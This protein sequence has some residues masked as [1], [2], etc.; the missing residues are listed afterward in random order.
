MHKQ[1]SSRLT[2]IVTLTVAVALISLS[3][4]AQSNSVPQRSEIDDKYKWDLTGFFPSDQAW[5]EEF[6]SVQAGLERLEF[7]QGKLGNSAANLLACLTLRDS[8]EAHTH[9]LYAYANLKNDQ[10]TR[11]SKYQ[12]MAGR[13]V[14]LWGQLSNA[15]SFIQ[16]E[17]TK[18]EESQV[19]ALLR[20]N[21]ALKT[22]RFFLEDIL[23]TKQ[24]ILS[25]KEEAI[26][27]SAFEVTNQPGRIFDMVDDADMDYGTIIDDNGEEIVLT[28]QRYSR[29]LESPDRETRRR[30]SEAYNRAYLNLQNTLA[31]LMSASF[32]GDYFYANTRG[33]GSCL[34]ASLDGNNIPP[35]VFHNLIETT[36]EHLPKLHKWTAL[37]KQV[38]GLDTLYK[39]DQ[40][41][42]LVP[43]YTR[44]FTY[45][46]AMELVKE[47]LKPLGKEYTDDV[48]MAFDS[49]WVDVY[50][51]EGKR[52]GG[53]QWGSYLAH[54]VILMNFT[55]NLEEVF[56]L[57]HEIG[58]CLN[59]YYSNQVEPYVY[60]GQSLFTAEVA[61]TCNEAIL[62]RY[63]LDHAESR[64]EKMYILTKYIEQI[65]GTFFTQV[66]FSEFEYAMH[67]H[68]EQGGSFS[69]E[70][71]RQTYHDIYKKYY[72]PSLTMT[73]LDDLGGLRISH[74]YRQY[75]VYQYATGIAA[76][77]AL[78]DK[79]LENEPGALDKYH[80][81]LRR[82]SSK[83]PID[84]L[85]D[86]GVDMTSADPVERTLELFGEL[87][88][89][90]ERLVSE[91]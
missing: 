61:S 51:T 32:K 35:S 74:F 26:L 85:K 40:Y 89:E 31:A 78:S 41:A 88:D 22:Y 14:S 64:E 47:G 56:T 2:V 27:A 65:A 34:E 6:T 49:R 71:M 91:S 38:L 39:Y 60:S 36:N 21:P 44:Q 43:D 42:A 18:M 46:E 12:E 20:E 23:R 66:M 37:R 75:Y 57:A 16:P 77:L 72:G 4:S 11:E 70:F 84:I 7:Y 68:M 19:R 62:M 29:L 5:E 30:A 54:P 52:S 76:A 69:A 48:Q 15:S 1:F 17:V 67:S 25:E 86:A 28:K 53:Y 45:D 58:H 55:G 33:Y 80:A 73:E 50:E 8:L 83:Y 81:F 13:A 87:V 24:H 3:A 90:M 9:R 10:D 82:G 63:M 59:A 79:I